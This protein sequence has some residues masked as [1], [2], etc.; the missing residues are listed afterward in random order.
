VSVAGLCGLRT[1]TS[2]LQKVVIM[3]NV[4]VHTQKVATG[5]HRARPSLNT[6]NLTS[7]FSHLTPVDAYLW[8]LLKE[9]ISRDLVPRKLTDRTTSDLR[10]MIAQSV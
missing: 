8:G 6:L 7:L 5:D 3:K 1:A 2:M 10:A 4:S 9:R